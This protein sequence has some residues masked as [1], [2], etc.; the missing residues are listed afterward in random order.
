MSGDIGPYTTECEICG[1][2]TDVSTGK[3]LIL[4]MSI[5]PYWGFLETRNIK[6]LFW[7]VGQSDE[8]PNMLTLT[9]KS[10]IQ[11]GSFAF[12][13][14]LLSRAVRKGESGS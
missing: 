7:T 9:R 10:N 8:M 5:W 1:V 2:R 4:A 6:S 13:G 12:P 3:M 11:K 14:G